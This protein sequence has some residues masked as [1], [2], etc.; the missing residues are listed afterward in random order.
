MR[1]LE[2]RFKASQGHLTVGRIH[3]DGDEKE[4]AKSRVLGPIW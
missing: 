4:D 1:W 2:N 3:T